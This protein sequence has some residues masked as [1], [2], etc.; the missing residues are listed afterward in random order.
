MTYELGD[1]RYGKS[2]I[3]LVTVRRDGAHHDLR[4]V[5]VDV[6]LEGEFTAA[7]VAGD[8]ASVIAT[9]TMKNAV[10]AMARDGL[11]GSPEA[12]GLAVARHFGAHPQVRRA[13]VAIREHEWGRIATPAGPAK[14]AFVRSGR[15]SS[16]I[17]TRRSATR[18]TE[19]WRRRSR[20]RGATTPRRSIEG[21]TSP[22]PT[23]SPWSDC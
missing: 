10:Y 18:R 23:I 11:V 7:H 6:S 21:S 15:A 8:N 12:F 16:A 9:D 17:S 22:R 4:D 1:N 20:R 13:T 19:S 3:R 14:D 2:R 5:T